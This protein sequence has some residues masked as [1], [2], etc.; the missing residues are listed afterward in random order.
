[1]GA[2]GQREA[3]PG[4]DP[5]NDDRSKDSCQYFLMTGAMPNTDS[6]YSVG[7]SDLGGRIQSPNR[8]SLPCFYSRSNNERGNL[9]V[10][11]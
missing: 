3:V 10:E 1:M 4:R 9:R 6:F 2:C 11:G 8:M 5:S 7:G